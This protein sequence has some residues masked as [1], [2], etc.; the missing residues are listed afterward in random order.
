MMT[1]SPLAEAL[2][3][4]LVPLLPYLAR[5]GEEDELAGERLAGERWQD[6]KDLW[7]RLGPLVAETPEAVDAGEAAVRL[8]QNPEVLDTLTTR[9][10]ALL[11][12]DPDLAAELERILDPG[13]VTCGYEVVPTGNVSEG[14]VV[15]DSDHEVTISLSGDDDEI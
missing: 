9:L 15:N 3:S 13:R 14:T 5:T 8:P 4:F 10:T 7:R 6:A 11:E 1:I 12:S 2:T